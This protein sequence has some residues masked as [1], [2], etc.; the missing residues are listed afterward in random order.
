LAMNLNRFGLKYGRK[1]GL[2]LYSISEMSSIVSKSHFGER[3]SIERVSL[4]G[5]PIFMLISLM[6]AGEDQ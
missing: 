5:L 1:I 3:H 4:Q 6:K 2:R